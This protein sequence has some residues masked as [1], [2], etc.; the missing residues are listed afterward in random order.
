MLDLQLR[1]L[2]QMKKLDFNLKQTLQSLKANKHNAQ[3][4]TYMLLTDQILS[5]KIQ[6]QECK[7]EPKTTAERVAYARNE[8]G[9]TV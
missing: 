5:G 3:T 7:D 1:T 4:A 2:C 9:L 6:I 8:L